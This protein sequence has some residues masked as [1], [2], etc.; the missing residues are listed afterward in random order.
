MSFSLLMIWMNYP[1]PQ[2]LLTSTGNGQSIVDET[3][4]NERLEDEKLFDGEEESLPV[5]S[6]VFTAVATPIRETPTPVFFE[7]PI[8]YGFSYEQRRLWRLIV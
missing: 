8:V 6:P 5:I 7:G 2:R 1:L 3:M 4:G